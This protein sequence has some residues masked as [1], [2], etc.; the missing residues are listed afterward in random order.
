MDKRQRRNH[1]PLS[2]SPGRGQPRRLTPLKGTG[3]KHKILKISALTML[4]KGEGE[5]SEDH[6]REFSP[7]YLTPASTTNNPKALTISH[8]S[9]KSITHSPK[10][11]L[12]L[13]DLNKRLDLL[14]KA[15]GNHSSM[16][17]LQNIMDTRKKL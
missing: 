6:S 11:F 5:Y 16:K 12:N 17:T 15:T 14:K 9:S 13:Y 1:L 3:Q 10:A 2:L 4:R 8:R 7:Q